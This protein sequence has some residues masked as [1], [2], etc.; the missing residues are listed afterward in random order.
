MCFPVICPGCT[1]LCPSVRLSVCLS[2]CLLC[3]PKAHPSAQFCRLP[4]VVGLRSSQDLS[5]QGSVSGA[6]S[7][8][9]DS[10]L[11]QSVFRR[12]DDQAQMPGSIRGT[13]PFIHVIRGWWIRDQPILD[14]T[15]SAE[16]SRWLCRSHSAFGDSRVFK[17]A[18][19]CHVM[20]LK[21]LS[22]QG[23]VRYHAMKRLLCP[24][25]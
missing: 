17:M 9:R 3:P 13:L 20:L 25:E 7:A 16:H 23:A 1:C 21:P 2:F 8:H 22:R 5:I 19:S 6:K 4:W 11:P 10:I 14:S 15:S 12:F 24:F 18:S